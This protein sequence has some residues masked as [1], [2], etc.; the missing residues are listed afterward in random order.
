MKK[1]SAAIQN[2]LEMTEKPGVYMEILEK[3]IHDREL[4]IPIMTMAGSY[5]T[6]K[7]IVE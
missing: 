7:Q 4:S 2:S 1:E 6:F 3:E 5:R